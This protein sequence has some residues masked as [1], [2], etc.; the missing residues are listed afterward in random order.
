MVR[1]WAVFTAMP[2]SLASKLKCNPVLLCAISWL[3][4]KAISI[5]PY[6]FFIKKEGHTMK[7]LNQCLDVIT[8]IPSSSLPFKF[9]FYNDGRFLIGGHLPYPTFGIVLPF[10]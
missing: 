7:A 5:T 4:L 1:A 2:M 9:A 3:L 10:F 6:Q 8:M